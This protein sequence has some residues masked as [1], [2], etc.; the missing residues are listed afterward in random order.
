MGERV[1]I[2]LKMAKQLESKFTE[3]EKSKDTGLSVIP[4]AL[5]GLLIIGLMVGGIIA[6]D[7][8]KTKSRETQNQYVNSLY[9]D[10]H[11]WGGPFDAYSYK[12]L[13][14]ESLNMHVEVMK[15]I[16]QEEA[17]KKNSLNSLY[18]G[19]AEALIMKHKFSF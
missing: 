13:S 15:Q 7:N 14:P 5:R 2:I 4:F 8:Y 19:D 17:K 6:H 1:L 3:E 12:D 10:G 16:K 9:E 18:W 11:V